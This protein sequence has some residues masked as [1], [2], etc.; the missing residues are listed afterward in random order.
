MEQSMSFDHAPASQPVKALSWGYESLDRATGGMGAGEIHVLVGSM[1]SPVSKLAQGIAVRAACRGNAVRYFSDHLTSRSFS[2]NCVSARLGLENGP[3]RTSI[4]RAEYGAACRD[5]DAFGLKFKSTD[6]KDEEFEVLSEECAQAGISCD[7]IVIDCGPVWSLES[8]YRV[9]L[10]FEALRKVA[11][12]LEAAV[13]VVVHSEP[14]D[15]RLSFLQ[16]IRSCRSLEQIASVVVGIHDPQAEDHTCRASLAKNRAGPECLLQ[17]RL[18]PG[19]QWFR[20]PKE[21]SDSD[22]WGTDMSFIPKADAA[23]R[24]AVIQV[25]S[26]PVQTRLVQIRMRLA[27]LR[28]N[29]IDAAVALLGAIKR[30]QSSVDGSVSD[31]RLLVLQNDA[32]RL[33]E[34]T[35]RERSES[36]MLRRQIT[37]L[38]HEEP[39]L[40]LDAVLALPEPVPAHL[41]LAAREGR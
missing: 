41:E 4:S 27:Y 21:S 7:L 14:Q 13:V 5:L 26:E 10:S 37:L 20:D 23:K 19:T 38:E 9:E 29:R 1:D 28:D 15:S 11:V 16:T 34:A 36:K 22:A 12:K 24:A 25:D 39:G 3:L 2:R 31:E 35:R 17:F 33:A 30:A 32:A 18:S 40:L 6:L 8:A